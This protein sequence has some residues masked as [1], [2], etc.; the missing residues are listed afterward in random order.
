VS[1]NPYQS[2]QAPATIALGVNSGRR[3]DLRSVARFQKGILVCI[4]LQ[5][6]LFI[7]QLI[8]PP[9]IKWLFALAYLPVALAGTVFA[10]LLALKVYNA[11]LGVL[12]G[13]ATLLPCIGLIALLAINQR[14]T[15]VLTQNGIKVGLMGAS[16]SQV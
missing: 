10:V 11:V 9:E 12:F 1:D 7:A 2:P 13:L 8:A 16:L 6:I 4:L 5:I 14:A 3:E 15:G